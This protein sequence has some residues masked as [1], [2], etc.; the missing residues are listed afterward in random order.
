MITVSVKGVQVL[1]DT[2]NWDFRIGVKLVQG[3]S[4]MA[5]V[6]RVAEMMV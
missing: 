4:G 2:N 5:E 6:L 1:V 3:C